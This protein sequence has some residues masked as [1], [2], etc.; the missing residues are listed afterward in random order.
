MTTKFYIKQF[1]I[2]N[3]SFQEWVTANKDSILKDNKIIGYAFNAKKGINFGPKSL[4]LNLYLINRNNYHGK[5]VSLVALEKAWELFLI[6]STTENEDYLYIFRNPPIE[7]W[8]DTKNNWCKKI[9]SEISRMFDW[10]F[11]EA[12]SETYIA[13][14]KCYHRGNVYLGNLNYIRKSIYNSV[15]QSIKDNKLNFKNGTIISLDTPVTAEGEDNEV[16]LSDVIAAEEDVSEESLDYQLLLQSARELLSK[17]FSSR[18]IDQII[19]Y[20]TIYLPP[21]LYSRLRNWRLS[22]SPEELYGEKNY[23]CK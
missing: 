12:L 11:N 20:K 22:H 1:I 6:K 15:L 2:N 5:E 18:E 10:S 8:L 16:L 23:K 9:A 13:I 17:S 21:A 14:M 19:N 3:Y 4:I 7:N